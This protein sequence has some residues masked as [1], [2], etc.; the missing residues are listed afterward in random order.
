VI[1]VSVGVDGVEVYVGVGRTGVGLNM[2]GRGLASA[3]GEDGTTGLS[4]VGDSVHEDKNNKTRTRRLTFN[5][6][7]MRNLQ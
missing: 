7:G 3:V 6:F 2:E 1:G 5:T 4:D